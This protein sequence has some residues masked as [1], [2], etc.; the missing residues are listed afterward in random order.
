MIMPASIQE[1]GI[2]ST[3]FYLYWPTGSPG[4]YRHEYLPQV[5]VFCFLGLQPLTQIG[6]AIFDMLGQQ[7]FLPKRGSMRIPP[8][9]APLP[10]WT[11][12]A[13]PT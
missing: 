11:A 2:H 7:V 12:W 8:S 4:L 1:A 9:M 3:A 6:D 5:P 10:S 13:V